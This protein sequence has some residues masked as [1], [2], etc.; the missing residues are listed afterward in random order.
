MQLR[1]LRSLVAVSLIACVSLAAC[2]KLEAQAEKPAAS[3]APAAAF[4][5]G[6]KVDVNWSGSWWKGEVLAVKGDAMR[7]SAVQQ[8]AKPVASQL[9]VL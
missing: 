7:K 2:K 9:M 8:T 1:S 3:A 6:D 4:Q 5:A